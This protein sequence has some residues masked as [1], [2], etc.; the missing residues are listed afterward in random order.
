MPLGFLASYFTWWT[1]V[2]YFG[3]SFFLFFFL[4]FSFFFFGELIWQ[5]GTLKKSFNA[6]Q[7]SILSFSCSSRW[8]NI[9]VVQ[10][11]SPVWLFV[12]PGTPARQASLSYT[13]SWS[14]LKPM[15]TE[16]VMPSNHLFLCHPLFLPSNFPSIGVISNELVLCIRWPKY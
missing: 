3:F 14:L 10:S 9:A 5:L 11:L 15:S 12:I 1:G 7:Y 4:S 6:Q 2:F 16:S 13:I 8:F